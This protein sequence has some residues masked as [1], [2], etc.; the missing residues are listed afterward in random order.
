MFDS[1]VI[2]WLSLVCVCYV[3]ISILIVISAGCGQVFFEFSFYVL[4]V[5]TLPSLKQSLEKSYFLG[6]LMKLCLN[7]RIFSSYNS[8]VTFL[9]QHELHQSTNMYNDDRNDNRIGRNS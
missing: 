3:T 4:C 8:Y 2:L 9:F 7:E 1:V 6:K 5:Y